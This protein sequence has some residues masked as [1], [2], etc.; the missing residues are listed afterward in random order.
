MSIPGPALDRARA[1]WWLFVLA[2]GVV[3]AYIAQAF[4]GMLVLGAF[5]YYAT[6]PIYRRVSVAVDSDGIAATLTVLAVLVPVVLLLLYAGFQLFQA[7]QDLTGSATGG[8]LLGGYLNALPDQQRQAVLSVVE[9]P[10]QALSDPQGTVMTVLQAGQ[11]VVTAV[12]GGLTLLALSTALTF[13]LLK[14]DDGIAAG[15]VRLF[16]GRDTAAYAY[17]AAVDSDLESVFFGNFLFVLAMSVV[18]GVVYWATNAFAPGGLTVPA[19]PVLA[20]LTGLASLIPIVVGKVV[21]LP[22]VGYLAVQAF[23]TDGTS[24]AFV[25]GVLVVYFLLLDILPQTFLQPVITGRQLNSVMLM[26][27]YLLGPILFGWYGFFLM[28]ILFVLM[29]EAIRVALPELLH[30]DRL[31]PTASMGDSLGAS[32]DALGD[33][34]SEDGVGS[35]ESGSAGDDAST[36]GDGAPSGAPPADGDDATRGE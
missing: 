7:V 18:S 3:A 1:A 8:P 13:F 10:R 31:T 5:G 20:L 30:G 26:F 24:L 17:A 36:D 12:V 27:A 35:D 25:G 32:V 22:V 28:P 15:L 2:L 11:R 29:L 6:R 34:T 21:Y 16:G 23:R 33:G 19:V 4:V 14:N 9:N